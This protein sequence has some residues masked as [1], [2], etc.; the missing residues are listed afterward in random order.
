[1]GW[2]AARRRKPVTVCRLKGE[3]VRYTWTVCI[4]IKERRRCLAE[5][6]TRRAWLRRSSR[7]AGAVTT[8]LPLVGSGG[9]QTPAARQ[10]K[11][12]LVA[13]GAHVDDPQSGCGGAGAPYRHLGQ[14]VGALSSNTRALERNV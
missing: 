10:R 9:G 13:V 8:G 12:K 2:G 5:S 4:L 6:I 1:M 3:V 11:L 7:L 14:G